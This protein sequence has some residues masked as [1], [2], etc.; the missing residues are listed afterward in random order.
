MSRFGEKPERYG[1]EKE[2]VRIS[3]T[4]NKFRTEDVWFSVMALASYNHI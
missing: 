4:V 3:V 1:G 2:N